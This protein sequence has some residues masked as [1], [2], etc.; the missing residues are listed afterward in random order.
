MALELVAG[1]WGEEV[2]PFT[3]AAGSHP[4][5]EANFSGQTESLKELGQEKG[6]TFV[7]VGD[8]QSLD[9]MIDGISDSHRKKGEAL[10][11]EV[12]LETGITG[13]EFIA[14]VTP[15]NGFDLGGGQA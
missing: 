8:G 9:E 11:Q 5:K 10:H 15:Q 12:G 6:K 3:V 4:E 2:V 13:K 1:V 7:V 14:P